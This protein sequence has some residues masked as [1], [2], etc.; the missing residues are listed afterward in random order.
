MV[1]VLSLAAAVALILAAAEGL[2]TSSPVRLNTARRRAAS[3]LCSQDSLSTLESASR[4]EC[5]AYL[6][7]IGGVELWEPVAMSLDVHCAVALKEDE[8]SNRFRPMTVES[9]SSR[10]REVARRKANATQWALEV[11]EY[12]EAVRRERDELDKLAK[13]PW[14]EWLADSI[15]TAA[16]LSGDLPP[17][18]KVAGKTDETR[19]AT[20]VIYEQ[21]TKEVEE[22]Y[23]KAARD[24]LR[25]VLEERGETVDWCRRQLNITDPNKTDDEVLDE[26]LKSP[27]SQIP[28]IIVE[29]AANLLSIAFLALFFMLCYNSFTALFQFVGLVPADTQPAQLDNPFVNAG[30][31]LGGSPS[32]SPGEAGLNAAL[33]AFQKL[34]TPQ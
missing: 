9:L 1:Q 14:T 10:W 26:F 16:L 6:I 15:D 24:N 18:L 22:I 19:Y 32:T 30:Q 31:P 33:S 29:V 23:A 20:F 8:P 2:R 12:A 28:A 21:L 5:E 17:E 34:R 3:R 7:E 13:S 25:A 27:N 4:A 11:A